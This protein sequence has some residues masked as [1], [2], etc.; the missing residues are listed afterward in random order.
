MNIPPYEMCEWDPVHNKPAEGKK[1][2]GVWVIFHGCCNPA[3]FVIGANGKW[4]LCEWCAALP[5]FKKFRKVI[6]RG[7]VRVSDVR[8]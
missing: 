3:T 4:H 6:E 8:R 1:K 7:R 2:N 5:A